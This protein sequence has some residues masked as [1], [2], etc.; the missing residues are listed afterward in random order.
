MDVSAML[1]QHLVRINILKVGQVRTDVQLADG[2][3]K[4]LRRRILARGREW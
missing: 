3:T 4:P 1:L 2:M